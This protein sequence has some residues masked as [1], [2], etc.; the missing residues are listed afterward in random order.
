MDEMMLTS[1]LQSFGAGGG[2]IGANT[3]MPANGVNPYANSLPANNNQ[4]FMI[5]AWNRMSQ[6][7]K[8]EFALSYFQQRGQVMN[9]DGSIPNRPN[10]P[11]PSADLASMQAQIIALTRVQA[12]L[13]AQLAAAQ[14]IRPPVTPPTNP[15]T[16]PV[17]TKP[18]APPVKVV[19]GLSGYVEGKT[20]KGGDGENYTVNMLANTNYNILSDK[21]LG[22]NAKIGNDGKIT[23]AGL[24]VDGV[25]LRFSDDG[26][27]KIDGK[28]YVSKTNDGDGLVTRSSGRFV[29]T[30]GAYKITLSQSSERGIR[31]AIAG[32]DVLKDGV[33]PEGLWGATFD[34]TK[35]DASDIRA[36]LKAAEFKVSKINDWAYEEHNNIG[37]DID[38]AEETPEEINFQKW[39]DKTPQAYANRVY[40]SIGGGAFKY[41]G[42]LP[43]DGVADTDTTDDSTWRM[44]RLDSN[45]IYNVFSD[46]NVQVGAKFNSI[47]NGEEVP[48]EFGFYVDGRIIRVVRTTGS[49]LSVSV[50]G[51]EMTADGT[52][53]RATLSA[54]RTK[55]TVTGSNDGEAWSFDV[56]ADTSAGIP[57]QSGALE[58]TIKG[59]PNRN[60]TRTSGLWGAFLDTGFKGDAGVSNDDNGRGFIRDFEGSR[61]WWDYTDGDMSD[62]LQAYV[63]S[64]YDTTD[65]GFSVYDGY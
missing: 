47:E 45:K 1:L 62:A 46:Q 44:N 10:T 26:S 31:I 43:A 24:Y 40:G 34:G 2:G 19:T 56:T 17:E 12:E 23:A 36:L 53:G 11:N 61:T 50:D 59:Q 42:A 18:T 39:A 33:A 6:Q 32:T 4:Q 29:V 22:V 60:Q 7:Q 5:A 41:M 21:N 28:P 8:L 63:L 55:L 35:D 15:T 25:E 38:Q 3:A 30:Y 48:R 13:R 37:E 27:L 49:T 52:N 9:P 54:N 51:V 64:S 58:M 16:K 57:V 20:F 65:E 14:G